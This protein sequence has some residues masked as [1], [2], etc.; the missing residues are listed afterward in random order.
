MNS[1]LES[2]KLDTI[3]SQEYFQTLLSINYYKKKLNKTKTKINIYFKKSTLKLSVGGFAITIHTVF[4]YTHWVQK[5]QMSKKFWFFSNFLL[6]KN[7]IR[8]ICL[9]YDDF[10]LNIFYLFY[11]Y[12]FVYKQFIYFHK[13]QSIRASLFQTNKWLCISNK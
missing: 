12:Y 1:H 3:Q 8:N 7:Q 2:I 6:I 9:N 4:I 5:S 13:N 10:S 11:N